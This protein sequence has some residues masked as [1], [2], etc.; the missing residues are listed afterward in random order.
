MM[1]RKS[2]EDFSKKFTEPILLRIVECSLKRY[3]FPSEFHFSSTNLF[4]LDSIGRWKLKQ[5]PKKMR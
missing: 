2:F 3:T 5:K 1:L 4:T